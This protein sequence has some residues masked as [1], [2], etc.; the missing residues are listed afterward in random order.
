MRAGRLRKRN[1]VALGIVL[2]W[3]DCAFGLNPSLDVNQYAH[4]AWKIS[5]SFAKGVI[6]SIAQ[7]PDGYLW[8]GTEFGL[9]RFNG[10]RNL[11]WQPPARERLPSN[12][13]RKLCVGRDGRLWIGTFGGL[14]SWKD[15]RLTHYPELN[16]KIIETVFEDHQG[17]VW[18]GAWAPPAGRLCAIQS[19]RTQCYGED[20]RFGSAV[21]ALYEDS[22]G[23]LWA[24]A[25]T[26][27][28]RWNPGP[29]KLYPMPNWTRRIHA[30]I[31][32]GAG[33]GSDEHRAD[34]DEP[35]QRLR[36]DAAREISGQPRDR[37]RQDG[38]REVRDGDRPGRGALDIRRHR[39]RAG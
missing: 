7:T 2:A 24:G 19:G 9:L 15:G 38:R 33:G 29:P 12:D 26:G 5:E 21:T 22:G 34:G 17:T 25:T 10:I 27:L 13:V 28:W 37:H 6:F 14:A 32:D 35:P 23:N 39:R 4:T 11:E 36:A 31:E 1:T 30:L 18:V 8:L 3:C 20:G 16:G